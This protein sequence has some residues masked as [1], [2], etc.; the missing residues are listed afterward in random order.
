[1]RIL[2]GHNSTYYPSQGGGDKSNRL[3]MQALA[4]RGHDVRVVTRVEQFGV[5]AHEHYVALLTERGIVHEDMAGAV[6]AELSGVDART[7]TTEPNMRAYFAKQIAEFD[8]D[9]ILVSTDDPA[10]LLLEPALSAPR[11][12]V[13]YLVR[14]TIAV[15]F[16][17]DSSAQSAAKTERLRQ[18]DGVVGVSESVARY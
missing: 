13:V 17:G 1:M 3:L 7:L 14:A 6:R 12:R 16:G 4:A 18:V 8:P 11:A 10:H 9:V 2:L 5:L 15:P